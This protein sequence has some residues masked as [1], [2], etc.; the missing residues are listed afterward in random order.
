MRRETQF[1]AVDLV[2]EVLPLSD[3]NPEVQESARVLDGVAEVQVGA[4]DLGDAVVSGD[5][6][7]C[8]KPEIPFDLGDE[9]LREPRRVRPEAEGRVNKSIRACRVDPAVL[10]GGSAE[11]AELAAKIDEPRVRGLE[12]H[13]RA[14]RVVVMDEV[15]LL[16]SIR[17]LDQASR[18]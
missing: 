15:R 14:R 17:V 16:M 11:P 2:V 13:T 8:R 7:E 1:L 3:L 12:G 10:I 18:R 9:V 4:I 6:G 5:P